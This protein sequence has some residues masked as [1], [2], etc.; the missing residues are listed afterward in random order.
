[1]SIDNQYNELL[2]FAKNNDNVIEYH[3]IENILNKN[4]IH[5]EELTKIERYL[6]ENHIEIILIGEEDEETL[7]LDE[8]ETDS[9]VI[10]SDNYLTDD[11]IRMY[12]KEIGS[13][14]LLSGNEEKELAMRIEQGDV[15]AKEHMA[16]S[17]LKLVVSVA[18]RYV[19]GSGMSLQDLIQEGNIGLLKAVEKFDYHKGYKFSTYA[20][21]WIRQA[22][23]RAIS[24]QSRTIRIPVHMREQMNKMKRAARHFLSE[25]NR[26]PN[27]E[28]MAEIMLMPVERVEEIMTYIGDTISLET[29]V[30]DKEDSMLGDFI[31]DDGMPEQFAATEYVMLKAELEEVL[32]TLTD[33]EQRIIRQRFGFEDGRIR[34]LEEI[35]REFH[36]TRERIRQIEVRAIKRLRYKQN[37]KRLRAYID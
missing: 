37:I 33:R 19:A 21:W 17:N 6:K 10:I 7:K 28:E 16:N 13:Y 4:K 22:I 5:E 3:D 23:T 12:L 15:I 1:M 26:E 31:A 36:L 20:M 9:K 25:N 30:G 27:P 34:T 2:V 11:S 29:P 32:S 24:D 8:V 14:P 35:G 18:K